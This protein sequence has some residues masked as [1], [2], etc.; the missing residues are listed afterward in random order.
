MLFKKL[1]NYDSNLFTDFQ[2][3]SF[4]THAI[5]IPMVQKEKKTV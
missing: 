2:A 3:V 5:Q 1:R 4:S